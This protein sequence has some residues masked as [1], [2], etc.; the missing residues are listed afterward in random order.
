MKKIW[1]IC[2]A[3]MLALGSLGVGYAAWTD[4]VQVSG[5]VDTG[6]LKLGLY[7]CSMTDTSAPPNGYVEFPTTNPDQS[8]APGFAAPPFYLDKNVAWGS[9]SLSDGADADGIIDTATV[10]IFNAYP[11]YF[12]TVNIYP[13]NLGTIPLRINSVLIEW[14]GGSQLLYA[15]DYIAMD[16]NQDGYADVEIK[17]LDNFGYQLEGGEWVEI[18]FWIH[19]LQEAPQLS[20]LSFSA[21]M[22]GVQWDE[23]PIPHPTQT[24]G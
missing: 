3:L 21:T 13:I 6:T 18:S 19:V 2:L 7:S 1:V 17:W 11:C 23:Y 15:N 5:T 24:P 20:S 4:V 8:V 12:N 10:E 9:C 14:P 22:L 16:I